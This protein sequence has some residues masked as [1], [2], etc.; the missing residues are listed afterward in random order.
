MGRRGQLACLICLMTL[1]AINPCLRDLM[2][3]NNKSR[4]TI[5]EERLEQSLTRDSKT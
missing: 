1:H 5:D 4:L 3:D 2:L